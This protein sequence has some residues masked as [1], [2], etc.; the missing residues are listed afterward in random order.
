MMVWTM[1]G[2]VLKLMRRHDMDIES[3][4]R[5]RLLLFSQCRTDGHQTDAERTDYPTPIK[6]GYLLE[7]MNIL[8]LQELAAARSRYAVRVVD[9]GEGFKYFGDSRLQPE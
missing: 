8:K 3:V 9:R 7:V 2:P 6:H 1:D 4:G 5:T